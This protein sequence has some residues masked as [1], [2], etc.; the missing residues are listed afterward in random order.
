MPREIPTCPPIPPDGSSGPNK[1]E[2]E[3]E[4]ITP[5]VGGGVSTRLAIERF[6]RGK[7][8]VHKKWSDRKWYR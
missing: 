7:G 3:I 6:L 4:L 5:M 8:P 2:Y 1:R